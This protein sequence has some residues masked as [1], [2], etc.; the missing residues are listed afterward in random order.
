MKTYSEKECRELISELSV[1]AGGVN[2]ISP[3]R[4]HRYNVK[5]GLRN[6]DGTGVLTGLTKLGDVHGYVVSEGERVPVDGV[7]TYRG[8]DIREMVEHCRAEKRHGFDEVCYL[9]LMGKLPDKRELEEFSA[10]LASMR[11][12]PDGFIEDMILKAPSKDLMNKI[13]RG[14]M[15]LYSYDENPDDTDLEN[16]MRQSLQLV[17]QMPLLVAYAYQAKNHYHD[18]NSLYIHSSD[19]KLS[20][21]ENFLS[22]IRQDRHF[23]PIE[24]D[25]LDMML[26]IHAEHGGG[27]NSTFTTRVV[28]SSGTDTYSAIGAAIGSL[29]GP[30][31]GGANI[32]VMGMMS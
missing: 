6:E 8:I 17:A 25:I 26:M 14:T 7:L 29:K 4:F 30:R 12:L 11:Q 23:E 32:K 13:A 2:H 19:P 21:A 18:H 16:L 24:A 1:R 5:R 28:S 3:D 9:L 22:I 20:T 10:L 15:A 27:N 31:H